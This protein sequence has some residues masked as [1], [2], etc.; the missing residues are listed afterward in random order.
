MNRARVA[1]IKLLEGLIGLLFMVITGV[2]LAEVFCRYALGFSLSW[3]HELVVLLLIWVVWLGVPV[4]VDRGAHLA[5][6]F[7]FDLVNQ[8]IRRVLK[9]LHWVLSLIF[10][11]LVFL[12]TFPVIEA[13]EGMRLLTLPIATNA[14][15][16]A[17][18]VGS[19]L[20]VLVLIAKAFGEERQV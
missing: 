7:L 14:R 9:K 5:V 10:L 19:L 16:Y 6:T 18:T 15:Y 2:T 8:R 11:G 20:S 4:G 13:F 3:S 12:L 17:A 1:L